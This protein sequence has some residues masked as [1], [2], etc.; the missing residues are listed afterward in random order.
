MTKELWPGLPLA[1]GPGQEVDRRNHDVKNAL[2]AGARTAGSMAAMRR[3]DRDASRAKT[4]RLT[5]R[6]R[7]N[8]SST[9]HGWGDEASAPPIGPRDPNGNARW[10]EREQGFVA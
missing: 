3:G 2:S 1:S 8:P 10:Y 7:E 6:F 4:T 9:A 5:A